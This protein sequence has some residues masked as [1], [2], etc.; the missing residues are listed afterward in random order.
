MALRARAKQVAAGLDRRFPL[1]RDLIR[2]SG[3]VRKVLRRGGLVH[4]QVLPS[5]NSFFALPGTDG[6]AKYAKFHPPASDCGR[7]I[8]VL[9]GVTHDHAALRGLQAGMV[10]TRDNEP[11][12]RLNPGSVTDVAV[13]PP[14]AVRA[15]LPECLYWYERA[16]DDVPAGW[17]S[18]NVRFSSSAAPPDLDQLPPGFRMHCVLS[19]AAEASDARILDPV[20]AGPYALGTMKGDA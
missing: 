16:A 7:R 9:V 14:W 12:L 4:S 2:K 5:H 6:L 1:F 8:R 18:L 20:C 15:L 13:T 17:D 10:F 3:L 11:L 19:F